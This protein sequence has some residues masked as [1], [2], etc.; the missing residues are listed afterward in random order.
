MQVT[1]ATESETM[2]NGGLLYLTCQGAIFWV[3]GPEFHRSPV[4]NFPKKFHSPETELV[5][6]LITHWTSL[7]VLGIAMETKEKQRLMVR[8]NDEISFLV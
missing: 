5:D 1:E 7:S 4:W 8:I 2:D 3:V 6:C